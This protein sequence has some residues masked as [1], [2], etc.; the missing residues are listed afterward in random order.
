MLT[1][2][3]CRQIPGP[4][5]CGTN[6]ELEALRDQLYALAD[7]AITAFLEEQAQGR[8]AT[9]A[10]MAGIDSETPE[11]KEGELPFIAESQPKEIH[12]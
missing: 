8:R 6:A 4:G 7:I 12:Q 3:Q 1:I 2:E 5:G 9:P 10:A 11:Q